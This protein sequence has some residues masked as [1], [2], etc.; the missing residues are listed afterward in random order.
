M[1]L[2]ASNLDG[3]EFRPADR[4]ASDGH[5]LASQGLSSVLDLESGA[6]EAGAPGCAVGGSGFHPDDE[7]QQSNVGLSGHLKSGH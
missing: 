7:S 1:G 6:R 2:V 3:L 5:R 4:E